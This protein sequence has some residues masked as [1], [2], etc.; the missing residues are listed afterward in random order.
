MNPVIE[1]IMK[2]QSVRLYEPKPIPKDILNTIIEAGNK[3]PFMSEKRYQPWRFVVV[4]DPEY[5]W[6]EGAYA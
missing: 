6:H 1:T 3:A 5:R 2:R 4:E